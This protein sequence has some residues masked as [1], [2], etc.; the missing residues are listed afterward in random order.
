MH[1]RHGKSNGI[2]FRGGMT[3]ICYN[4]NTSVKTFYIHTAK[5][6][7]L[8]AEKYIST[9]NTDIMIMISRYTYMYLQHSI[10]CMIGRSMTK[11]ISQM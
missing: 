10:I 2:L 3:C 4:L 8:A 5:N 11:F 9:R 1:K 7:I 6:N